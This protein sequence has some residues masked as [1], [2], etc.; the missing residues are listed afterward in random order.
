MELV[1][2]NDL[3]GRAAYQPII[4]NQDGRH[5]AYMGHHNR[6]AMLN[7]LTG[8]MEKNGVSIVDVSD[9]ANT[10]Y[11]AHIPTGTAPR[12]G[13]SQM[14]QVCSGSVLPNGVDGKWYLLRPLGGLAQEIWTSATRRSQ[15][16]S[17]PSST[18]S[19]EPIRTGGSA[20]PVSPI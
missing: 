18:A 11:L 20:T 1:G 13:G 10:T 5:I 17:L 19:P 4:I 8:N 3:Q 9:P 15:R 6:D 12:T 16:F 2:H 14:V 7:P